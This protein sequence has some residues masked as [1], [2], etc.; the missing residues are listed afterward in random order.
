MKEEEARK[1]KKLE[2][3]MKKKEKEIEEMQ[4]Y[5]K[6]RLKKSAAAIRFIGDIKSVASV[7]LTPER[8]WKKAY[9]KAKQDIL[10]SSNIEEEESLISSST[11]KKQSEI[12]E[13]WSLPD[14]WVDLKEKANFKNTMGKQ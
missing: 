1:K 7:G 4:K 6:M 9:L 2:E 13:E 11:S 12:D 10:N 14:N 3:E 8:G 5:E